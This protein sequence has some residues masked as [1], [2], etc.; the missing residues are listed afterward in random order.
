MAFLFKSLF[1]A[2]NLKFSGFENKIQ[3]I[4]RDKIYQKYF[5]KYLSVCLH[6]YC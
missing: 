5:S 2:E 6:V 1:L 4:K 3:K